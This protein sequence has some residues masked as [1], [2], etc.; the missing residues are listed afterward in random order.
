VKA[1]RV[2]MYPPHPPHDPTTVVVREQ[3]ITVSIE[4]L[5][6]QTAAGQPGVFHVFDQFDSN[7]DIVRTSIHGAERI[8]DEERNMAVLYY[9]L[10]SFLPRMNP[11]GYLAT[12]DP[13]PLGVVDIETTLAELAK[14]PNYRPDVTVRVRAKD[15]SLVDLLDGKTLVADAG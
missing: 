12:K 1:I 2:S 8:R 3:D 6:Q 5:V 15:G 14:H 7:D 11:S 13:A 9:W 4:D 10:A